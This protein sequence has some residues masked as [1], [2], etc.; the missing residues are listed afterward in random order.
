MNV[1]DIFTRLFTAESFDGPGYTTSVSLSPNL[2][3]D[4]HWQTISG[5]KHDRTWT[6]IQELYTDSLTAWRKN[7]M[8]WRIINT[9]VNFVVGTGIELSSEDAA[10]D[11]FIKEFW[12]HRKNRMALRL[13]PMMEELSRSGDLFVL[14]FR[15]SIDGM[16]YIRFVTKDQ[17]QKIETAQNDWETELVYWETPPA[18]EYDPRKWLSPDHPDAPMADAIMLHY[19]VNRPIGALMGESDLT[20]IIPWLLRYSRMLEDR[21]RLHWAARA[22]LYLVTVPSNKVESKSTQYGSPPES[23]SI[24]VKDESETWETITPSLRGADAGHDMKAVR[25]MI[26]AGAGLPPHWRGEG[27]DVNLAT[28]EAMQGPPERFLQKRQQYFV[29]ML[30]DILYQAYLRA[31]EIAAQ[32]ALVQTDYEQLFKPDLP[33]VSLRDNSLLADAASALS[34]GFA[35]LQNTLLGKSPTLHKIAMDL[36]LK[37]AGEPQED[38]VLD[39]IISEAKSDPIEPMFMPGNQP[40]GPNV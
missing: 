30:E 14:L 20:T 9:T 39:K 17:I 5:R 27:G 21:V 11:Q 2:A 40:G 34:M 35:T 36:M 33:D 6:E 13:V 15:N 31:V 38:D 4:D 26:D 32:P 22:F 23:G 7:P 37:F 16:S 3:S 25:T 10:L 12:N 19:A 28:A 24:V 8:A 1:R 18:G 29:W